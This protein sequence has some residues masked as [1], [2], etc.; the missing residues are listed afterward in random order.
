MVK[1]MEFVET[2]IQKY[3]EQLIEQKRKSL[4]RLAKELKMEVVI[5]Q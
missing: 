2:G 5:S 1:G 4:N 3:E